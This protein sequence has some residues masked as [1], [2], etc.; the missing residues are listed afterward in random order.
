MCRGSITFYTFLPFHARW[1]DLDHIINRYFRHL[2]TKLQLDRS[3]GIKTEYKRSDGRI[4]YSTKY[5]LVLKILFDLWV[6]KK[7]SLHKQNM[8]VTSMRNWNVVRLLYNNH[9]NNN[10]WRQT[11]LRSVFSESEPS[12]DSDDTRC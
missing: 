9:T 2:C 10:H 3:N 8:C 12:R 6:R 1:S 7:C 11:K 4:I 5:L